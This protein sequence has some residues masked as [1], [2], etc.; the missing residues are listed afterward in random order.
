M[1]SMVIHAVVQVI[2]IVIILVSM[3]VVA[4]GA[5]SIIHLGVFIINGVN[6]LQ[7]FLCGQPGSLGHRNH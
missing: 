2:V 6:S 5:I 7:H 3:L 4:T 1:V